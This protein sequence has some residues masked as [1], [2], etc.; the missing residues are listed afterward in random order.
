MQRDCLKRRS[1][2]Q[3]PERE[4]S[5]Q[6]RFVIPGQIIVSRVMRLPLP[7]IAPDIRPPG[8]QPPWLH[9]SA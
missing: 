6:S 9:G 8:W 7:F 4:V 3:T 2:S 5:V 1:H